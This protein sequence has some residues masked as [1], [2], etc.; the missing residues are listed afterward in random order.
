LRNVLA[1]RENG[2]VSPRKLWDSALPATATL[3]MPTTS[4]LNGGDGLC[5]P[6]RARGRDQGINPSEVSV[7]AKRPA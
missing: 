1:K 7:P 6:H 4:F 2:Q 3:G 5:E